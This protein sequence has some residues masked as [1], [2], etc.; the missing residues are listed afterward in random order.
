MSNQLTDLNDH[1]FTALSRLNDAKIK[2]DV[3]KEEIDRARAVSGIAREIISNATLV[4]EA[5]RTLGGKGTPTMLGIES[6]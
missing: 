5:Q 4:L 1:L 3:L 2:G 6:K